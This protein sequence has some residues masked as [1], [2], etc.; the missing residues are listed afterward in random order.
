MSEHA[1][2][3]AITLGYNARTCALT[4]VQHCDGCTCRP[5]HEARQPHP[6]TQIGRL[7]R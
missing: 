7:N 4:D 3:C 2:G 1:K 6:L 5:A